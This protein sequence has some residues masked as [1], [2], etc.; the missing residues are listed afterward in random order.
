MA[1]KIKFRAWLSD[2]EEMIQV[3]SFWIS[4]NDKINHVSG[5]TSTGEFITVFYNFV[6]MQYTGYDDV[7]GV[8]IYEGDIVEHLYKL[9][10][11]H[12]D[13]GERPEFIVIDDITRLPFDDA[14]ISAEISG[15]IHNDPELLEEIGQ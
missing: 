8:E 3:I 11:G 10:L 7:N 5:Y 1:K 14:S 12:G 13:I 6:L 15:N 2:R 9:Y 4:E